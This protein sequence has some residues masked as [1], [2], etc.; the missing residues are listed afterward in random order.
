M[1][2]LYILLFISPLFSFSQ[3]GIGTTN[4]QADLHIAG[5]T[6]T[7]RIESLSALNSPL[8]N[9]GIKP[10]PA[11]VTANGDITIN[12]SN[13]NGEGSGGPM[14]P[15][16]FL[17]IVSDFIPNGPTNRGVILNNT[18]SVTHS[19]SPIIS[20]PFSSPQAALIEV[21]Y[22]LTTILSNTDLNVSLTP[23]N[24]ISTR[25][26]KYY[27]CIDL[28]NDGLDTTEES[29]KYGLS[30]QYYSSDNNGI[31]GYSFTNGHGYTDIPPG[32]HALVFFGEIFDGPSKHT[33]I[34][35]GGS[36]DQLKIRIYN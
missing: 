13:N 2:K 15:I 34:G 19:V 31:L 24:D 14:T 30:G 7:I 8:Y 3:I 10:A 18:T 5:N 16:N 6:S 17:S 29:K 4:P 26:I 1:R 33:S 9:D 20:I 36:N 25:A 21:K 27:F 23:F 28:N 22:T 11:Y 35:V 32:N 12:P